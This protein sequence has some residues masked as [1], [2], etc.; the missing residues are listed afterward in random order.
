MTYCAGEGPKG[1]KPRGGPEA[2]VGDGCAGGGVFILG[3]GR[4]C[5]SSALNIPYWL[6]VTPGM[7]DDDSEKAFEVGRDCR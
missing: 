5:A 3:N 4:L 2:I 7:L 1:T 6:V